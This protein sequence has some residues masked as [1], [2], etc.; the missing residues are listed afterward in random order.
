M[1]SLLIFCVTIALIASTG[2]GKDKTADNKGADKG[3]DKGGGNSGE[4]HE[5]LFKANLAL[6]NEYADVLEKITNKEDVE[7]LKPDLEKIAQKSLDLKERSMKLGAPKT[8]EDQDKLMTKYL[9]KITEAD[10]RAKKALM[11]LPEEAQAA[12]KAFKIAFE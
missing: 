4:T 2:C 12:V 10:R 11:K 1:R 7:K 6:I 9:D 5:D 8:K 3:A